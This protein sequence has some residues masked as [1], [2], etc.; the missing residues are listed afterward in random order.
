HRGHGPALDRPALPRAVVAD[1]K[2]LPGERLLDRPID[3]RDVRVAAG[4][5]DTLPRVESEDPGG[6]RG[7]DVGETLERHPP[8]PDPFGI[9]DPHP[10]LGAKIAASHV[11]EILAAELEL[12]RR[13]ELVRRRR[14]HPVAYEPVPERR[15]VL[16]VLERR[17]RVV[18]EAA[19]RLVVLGGEAGVVVERLGVD[20]E[21]R[22]AGLDHRV[23]ALA[24]RG[25]DEVDAGAGVRGELDRAAERELLRELVVYERQQPAV[26]LL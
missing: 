16:G 14:R 23:Y 19:G 1:V 4:G 10:R 18:A 17:I 12:E 20:R 25:V 5:D 22:G 13:R 7:G 26:R 8:L 2:I 24:G 9:D 21:P 11:L 6:V 15:L 3:D